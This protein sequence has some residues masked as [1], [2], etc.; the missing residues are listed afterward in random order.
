VSD[1]SPIFP[2]LESLIVAPYVAVVPYSTFPDAV[3]VE[4][5]L[6]TAVDPVTDQPTPKI[7]GGAFST[8][9]DTG[10]DTEVLPEL[11]RA[12]AVRL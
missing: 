1:R 12:L 5:Q 11:S 9:T 3:W 2:C 8:T 4:L 10:A 7:M 6:M